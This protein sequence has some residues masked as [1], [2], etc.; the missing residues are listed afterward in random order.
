[1]N[2]LLGILGIALVVGL[3]AFVSTD[4]DWRDRLAEGI[5]GAG[6]TAGGCLILL[7]QLSLL[8]IMGWFAW[9]FLS[10]IFG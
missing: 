9:K 5:G 1:M 8:A 3:I 7:F 4:G 6:A 2:I 10:W